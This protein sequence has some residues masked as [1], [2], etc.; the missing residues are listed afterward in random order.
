MLGGPFASS[1]SPIVDAAEISIIVLLGFGSFSSGT[2]F[3]NI[4]GIL[5]VDF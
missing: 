4:S 2:V 3:L 1:H 5:M